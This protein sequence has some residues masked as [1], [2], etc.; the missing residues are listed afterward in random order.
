MAAR[1]ERAAAVQGATAGMTPAIDRFAELRSATVKAVTEGPGESSAA[2][3]QALL[4]GEPPEELRALC[5]TIR[6]H[7]WKVTDEQ[8]AELAARHG[9]EQAFEII[10][11][12]VLG[13]AGD[14]LRAG[15]AALEEA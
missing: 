8:I 15:L 7:A 14:R 2:L 11:A 1:S 10:V 13:A 5:E 9:Y 12:T 4:R 3:R 6:A